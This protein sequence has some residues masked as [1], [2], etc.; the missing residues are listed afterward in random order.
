MNFKA[1]SQL[2]LQEFFNRPEER[3]ELVNGELKPK[4]SPK[5]K[6][7]KT[8]GRLYRLLDDWCEQQQTGRVLPEWGVMLKREGKDWVPIPDLTY[9]S[10]ERLSPEWEDD[11]PCPVLPELVIEIISPGQTFGGLTEKAED[12]LT[13]GVDR[14][15]IVDP[16]EQTVT[17]FRKDRGFETRR[18]QELLVDS[19]LPALELPVAHLFNQ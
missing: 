8:Q 7:S 11:V 12:Y 15:W 6:H 10:Y 18:D 1:T 13:A 19:L 9:V 14:V 2:S 17:V 16:Q 5:F 4:V 3:C